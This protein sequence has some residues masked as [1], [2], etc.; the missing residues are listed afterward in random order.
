LAWIASFISMDVK[1]SDTTSFLE[2]L[3]GIT[4]AFS[5]WGVFYDAIVKSV[6]EFE[7]KARKKLVSHELQS[8]HNVLA[9][10]CQETIKRL[11][12]TILMAKRMGYLLAFAILLAI[13]YAG[14][15]PDQNLPAPVYTLAILL[16][17]YVPGVSWHLR[18]IA[19]KGRIETN[20]WLD[21]LCLGACSRGKSDDLEDDL[22]KMEETIGAKEAIES[23]EGRSR[24][25]RTPTA[26]EPTRV[27][28]TRKRRT[29]SIDT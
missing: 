25:A 9:Q 29:D 5:T 16:V 2:V 21:T 1:L 14:L 17:F 24:E 4:L 23:G 12:E 11:N 8:L 28:I 22:A 10:R 3:F 26:K 18:K 6:G 27:I 13:F 15:A 20:E 7:G 19:K